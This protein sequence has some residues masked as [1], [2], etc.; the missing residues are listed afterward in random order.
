MLENGDLVSG[1]LDTTIKIWNIEDGTVRRTLSGHTEKVLALQVLDNGD[2]VSGS[3]DGTI[4]IWD[5]ENGTL[6]KDIEVNSDAEINALIVLPNGDLVSEYNDSIQ[7][8][9]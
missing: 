2:L 7:I 6:K 4:K 8:W 9:V 3:S 1:S 5:V